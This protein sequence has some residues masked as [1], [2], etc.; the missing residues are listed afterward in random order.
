MQLFFRRLPTWLT[1]EKYA[2]I[3]TY[4]C[5]FY[6]WIRMYVLCDKINPLVKKNIFCINIFL[7][8][9]YLNLYANINK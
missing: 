4:I 6:I 7:F 5:I 9:F 8:H 1:P 2:D 3:Y